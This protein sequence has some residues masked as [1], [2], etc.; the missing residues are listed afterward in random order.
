MADDKTTIKELKDCV[1]AFSTERDW[2]KFHNPKNLCMGL[3]VETGELLE[4]FIWLTEQQSRQLVDDP[5]QKAL[6]E[7]EIADVFCYLLN[8][9]AVTEI[10]LS[11]AFYRKMKRNA[12]KY[13]AEQ[14]RG[15]Y[16]I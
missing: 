5:E 3:A 14:Y 11:E 8:L 7:E 10:D 16:K 4:H 15:K 12:E 6:V 1:S 13:P 9:A 2:H